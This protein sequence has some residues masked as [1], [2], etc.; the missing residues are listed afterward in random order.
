L[1]DESKSSGKV[2]ERIPQEIIDF[3]SKEGGRSLLIKGSAG[4][5]KTT[6]ALQLLEEFS[7]PDSSYYISTRVSDESLYNQFPWLKA[8]EMRGRV[9]DSSRDFLSALYQRAQEG[10]DKETPK[11]MDKK[12]LGA[13]EFLK[14]LQKTSAPS[15]VDRAQLTMLLEEFDY[16]DLLE[17]RRLYDRIEE[18]L[19][20]KCLCVIDSVEGITNKYKINPDSLIMALQKDLVENS[21]TN[22]LFVMEFADDT[23]IDYLVDGVITISRGE[24]EGRRIREILLHKL[25]ATEIKQPKYLATLKGG[26]FKSFD[27]FEPSVDKPVKWTPIPDT[28]FHYSTGTRPMDELLGGGY[29]KGTYNVIEVGDNVSTEE[30]Y[31]IVRPILLNFISHNRGAIA[32]LTGGDHADALRTDLVRFIDGSQFDKYVHI[33][34]YFIQETD[35]PY[36][37]ALGTRNKEEAIR[38]WRRVYEDLRGPD[39][40]NPRPIMDFAG[41]DTLE[42]LRGGDVAIKDLFNTVGGIKISQDLG[43]GILKPGLKLK[44]EIMNMADTYFKIMD[45]NKSCCIYG[46]KPHTI[47][48]VITPDEKKGYPYVEFNP[49]V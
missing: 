7:D 18:K 38:V 39:K 40:K 28:N 9:I 31:S 25:R 35:K 14:S 12:L 42:Y 20:Q 29:G 16:E 15:S 13:R 41:F 6:F 3:Y 33:A 17:I 30:Y 26:R 37:M 44:Q 21:N 46:I 23:S 10:G 48:Y 43:I 2:I 4:T 27:P 49:V 24:I 45:I 34:D 22:L 8:K 1:T 11:Q 19:P 47:V 36:V 32:V 5:G